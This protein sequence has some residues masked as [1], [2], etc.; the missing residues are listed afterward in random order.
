MNS[1]HVNIIKFL[2]EQALPLLDQ[3]FPRYFRKPTKRGRK[4]EIQMEFPWHAK[5]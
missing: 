4:M 1:L 2:I 5:K 3:R